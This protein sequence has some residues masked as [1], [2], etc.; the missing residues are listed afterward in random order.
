[1]SSWV[2]FWRARY[3]GFA[4]NTGA[5]ELIIF[6]ITFQLYWEDLTISESAE[7]LQQVFLRNYS[8]NEWHEKILPEGKCGELI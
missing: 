5:E 3:I 8:K 1:M 7:N 4:V 2:L 6:S